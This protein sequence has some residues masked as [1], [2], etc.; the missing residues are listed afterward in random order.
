MNQSKSYMLSEEDIQL[1]INEYNEAKNSGDLLPTKKLTRYF[2]ISCNAN[3]QKSIDILINY[4][5]DDNRMTAECL[6]DLFYEW[7]NAEQ[8][9]IK[10]QQMRLL[11]SKINKSF[12]SSISGTDS[13][14]NVI[15]NMSYECDSE[16][17]FDMFL[18]YYPTTNIQDNKGNTP[19]MFAAQKCGRNIL[20]KLCKKGSLFHRQNK[21]GD[22]SLSVAIEHLNVAGF[23]YIYRYY[24]NNYFNKH[25][26]KVIKKFHERI[27]YYETEDNSEVVKKILEILMTRKVSAEEIFNIMHECMME[28]ELIAS[29]LGK[30]FCMRNLPEKRDYIFR[31]Y[32]AIRRCVINKNKKLSLDPLSNDD[33][34]Y[35]FKLFFS[36]KNT[37]TICRFFIHKSHSFDDHNFREMIKYLPDLNMYIYE[38][39]SQMVE[40]STSPIIFQLA[41]RPFILDILREDKSIN[42]YLRQK[43]SGVPGLSFLEFVIKENINNDELVNYLISK[44]ISYSK[45]DPDMIE[46]ARVLEQRVL[47]VAEVLPANIKLPAAINVNHRLSQCFMSSCAK[48]NLEDIVQIIKLNKLNNRM[49][50]SDKL[51]TQK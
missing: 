5:G 11:L 34:D 15:L 17:I 22:T 38:R 51:L 14:I 1:F 27:V 3:D 19:I 40:Y 24:P 29:K 16:K 42:I 35:L 20:E 48:G 21:K 9:D 43:I 26:P 10:Y 8:P 13:L 6:D 37:N 47:P 46:G 49:K 12:F 45:C 39:F 7:C 28:D 2:Q 50:N 36:S 30:S 25:L 18:E 23:Q 33:Y 32:M 4:F 41:H 44:H 31:P